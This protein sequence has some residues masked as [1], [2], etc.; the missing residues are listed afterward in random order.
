M[1]IKETIVYAAAIVAAASAAL[2][3]LLFEVAPLFKL[4]SGKRR[5]TSLTLERADGTTVR[6]EIDPSKEES[7]REFLEKLEEPSPGADVGR[8]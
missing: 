4:L 2:K 7:V 1:D 3:L 8:K 6:L 5:A